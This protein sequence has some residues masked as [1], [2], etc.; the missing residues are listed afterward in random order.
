M[1]RS[2]KSGSRAS[3]DLF[4]NLVLVLPLPRVLS[5]CGLKR[6]FLAGTLTQIGMVLQRA[7]IDRFLEFLMWY[8]RDLVPACVL[9]LPLEGLRR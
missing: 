2:V 6:G 1:M 5:F 3:R 9:E 7:W 4:G 8:F